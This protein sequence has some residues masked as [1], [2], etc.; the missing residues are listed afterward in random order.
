MITYENFT[1][2]ILPFVRSSEGGYAFVKNDKGGETYAGITR[3]NNPTWRG[4]AIIDKAKPLK[5][6]AFV[7]AAETAVDEFYWNRF[8]GLSLH[9]LNSVKV[10]LAAFDYNV[11]GGFSLSTLVRIAKEKFSKTVAYANVLSWANQQNEETLAAAIIDH[12]KAYLKGLIAKDPTQKV[13]EKN[14]M[15]RLEKLKTYINLKTVGIS[16][17]LVILIVAIIFFLMK[18]VKQ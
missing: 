5:W 13:F 15:A 9:N 12:R 17:G 10:A 16:A 18:G 3:K 2:S 1:R 4:W 7:K 8:K 6:N 11:H 14:W